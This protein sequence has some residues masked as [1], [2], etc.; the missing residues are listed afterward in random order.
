MSDDIS[1]QALSGTVG[2]RARAAIAAGCD[3][4]LHCNGDMSE[5]VAVAA[6]VPELTGEAARR[7][8]A[9]LALRK[10]PAPLDVAVGR[11]DF[12]RL[13]AGSWQPA[14]PDA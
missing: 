9:A 2:E 7:A 4:V 10:A 8:D 11:A 12:F 14:E 6:E 3:V 5:M 13:M 1:M